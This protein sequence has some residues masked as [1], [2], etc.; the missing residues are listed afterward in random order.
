M[1]GQLSAVIH[2]YGDAS[3]NRPRKERALR[4]LKL[5]D[6]DLALQEDAR[7]LAIAGQTAL[8]FAEDY[9]K[10][11]RYL[12][13]S[14]ELGYRPEDTLE[15][16]AEAH[17]RGGEYGLALTL[18]REA[19]AAGFRSPALCLNMANLEVRSGDKRRGA[20]LLREC[21]ERGGIDAGTDATIRQNLQFLS[22][23]A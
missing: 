6:E 7:L 12:R 14:A 5:M 3:E 18:Y 13:R 22:Q 15:S 21:L 9:G 20:E 17:Y 1:R 10:A 4:Y 16:A 19:H 23:E 11:A 8:H 2:H